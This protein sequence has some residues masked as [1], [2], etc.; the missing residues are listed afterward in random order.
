MQNVFMSPKTN[1]FNFWIEF[2][3]DMLEKLIKNGLRPK[4]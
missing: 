4:N 3:K 2:H 1:I